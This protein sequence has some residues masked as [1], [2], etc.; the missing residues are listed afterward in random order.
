MEKILF[1]S[2][3]YA[4]GVADL[5]FFVSNQNGKP[6]LVSVMIDEETLELKNYGKT[7][8][9]DLK[10]FSTDF[11]QSSYKTPQDGRELTEELVAELFPELAVTSTLTTLIYFSIL[12]AIARAVNFEW[13]QKFEG[14][15]STEF[16]GLAS[17]KVEYITGEAPLPYVAMEISFSSIKNGLTA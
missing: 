8:K 6:S 2:I 4:N 14:D 3:D 1:S 5:Q 9:V 16:E 12:G 13:C 11:G 17:K 7:W 15:D 10:L